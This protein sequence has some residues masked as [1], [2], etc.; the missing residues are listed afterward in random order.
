[1]EFYVEEKDAGCRLDRLL[2][3]KTGLTRTAA[4]LLAEDNKVF[5]N[6]KPAQKKEKP[7]IGDLVCVEIPEPR[8]T[9]ISAQ[10]IPLEIVFEDEHLLVVNKCRGMVV[11]PAPGHEDGTLV[12]A[13]LAH[14]GNSL[15]GINGVIRPGIVHRIDKD[16]SGLLIVAKTNEAHLRLAEMIKT[17]TFLRVYNGIVYGALKERQGIIDRP[18]GRDPKDRKKMAV[19]LK[20]SRNAITEYRVLEELDRASLVEFT[21]QTGRTH[22]IRVHMAS[23]GHAIYGDPLYSPGN[24]KASELTGQYLHAKRIGFSHPI[25][26]QYMEFESDLPAYMQ[27]FIDSHRR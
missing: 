22:Q 23:L 13:L 17:H 16:T 2:A 4:A 11:H 24:I 20:N 3:E 10:E 6:G 26:G 19:T 21:L 12:N 5:I 9:G 25:T 18:I 15:S 27:E 7:K 8:T 14:C 1:M